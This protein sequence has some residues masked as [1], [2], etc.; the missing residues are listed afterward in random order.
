[1]NL[2]RKNN[3]LA[4]SIFLLPALLWGEVLLPLLGETAQNLESVYTKLEQSHI[5]FTN[6]CESIT[7]GEIPQSCTDIAAELV[8][9]QEAVG[10][11]LA[12]VIG[13]EEQAQEK[14]PHATDDFARLESDVN[15]IVGAQCDQDE[16]TV[17]GSSV[18][19]SWDVYWLPVLLVW[20]MKVYLIKLSAYKE[21]THR[22]KQEGNALLL[23]MTVWQNC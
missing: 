10:V 23:K 12:R 11:L 16:A 18:C 22:E 8:N 5:Y 3:I 4:I 9:A 7:A 19:K 13:D 2:W 15:H 6:N 21:K 1:M 17:R 14:C 20:V